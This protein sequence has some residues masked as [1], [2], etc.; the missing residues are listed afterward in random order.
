MERRIGTG[1]MAG[2]IAGIVFTLVALFLRTVMPGG[3]HTSMLAVA[4]EALH[5]HGRL[6]GWVACLVY[7]VI[8]G[9]VFGWLASTEP[10]DE[11]RLML[12]GGLYGLAWW[13]V[14]ALVLI[15]A[16][17]EKVPL[18]SAALDAMR[19]LALASLVEHVLY[20]VILGFLLGWLATYVDRRHGAHA[21]HHAA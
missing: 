10:M 9:G 3:E 17:L 14:S 1:L 13:M 12:L 8:I 21:R 4:A 6:A 16:L 2:L 15:P 7:T 11:P 19:P 18:S 20:G 5:S